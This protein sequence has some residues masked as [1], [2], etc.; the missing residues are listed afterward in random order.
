MEGDGGSSVTLIF[1]KIGDA[2]YRE[3]L[4]NVIAAAA[5]MSQLTHVEI[6][7][8]ECQR[9]DGAM[10]NVARIFNDR[11]GAVRKRIHSNRAPVLALA[12]SSTRTP[13]LGAAA[14]ELI[15]RTGRSPHYSYLSLGCSKQAER[16][17]LAYARKAV[18]KPFSA[19]AMARSVLWP[20]QTNHESFFCA[21]LVAAILR[22]GGLLDRNSN[23][24]AATPQSLYEL[25]KGRAASTANPHTL[26]TLQAMMQ[27]QQQQQALMA[28]GVSA[29]LASALAAAPVGPHQTA[30][31]AAPACPHPH[32]AHPAHP[33]HPAHAVS[34]ARA[35][36]AH[37]G[38]SLVRP[39]AAHQPHQPHQSQQ[40]QQPQQQ[41][42]QSTPRPTP[43]LSNCHGPPPAGCA[44][45]ANALAVAGV[46]DHHYGHPHAPV[47]MQHS[48][49]GAAVTGSGSQRP[50]HGRHESPPRQRFRPL[51]ANG[52]VSATGLGRATCAHF[53]E[54]P[55]H[56]GLTLDSLNFGRR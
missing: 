42:L 54:Q 31:H 48:G 46:V 1:Y 12:S 35:V 41:R 7:I 56:L 10:T 38:G 30:A 11:V 45:L 23:P 2:W 22:E 5:Q 52:S 24:G 3:P 6:A 37:V 40:P 15:A 34:L 16:A 33:A 9:Q 8:G 43:Q 27:Q 18:G 28:S 25:Y 26:H 32:A 53:Q 29:G 44:N 17:M 50:F 39:A 47:H 36:G 20:R 51:G 4:L 21:E 55:L 19:M 14:Q 49:G 13:A